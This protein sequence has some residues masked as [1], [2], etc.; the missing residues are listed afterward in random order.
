[1]EKNDSFNLLKLSNPVFA[2]LEL[3][4]RC[5]N[6]CPGCPSGRDEKES[7][8]LSGEEW[9]DV[10]SYL[11]GFI[12]EIRLTGGEPTYHP[13]FMNILAALIE[14]RCGF[15]IYTNGLWPDTLNMFDILKETERFNGFVFSIHGSN[16]GIHEYFTGHS[17]YRKLL[18]NIQAAV[19]K[20]F[21]VHTASVLGAFNSGDISGIIRRSADL[22]AMR[23]CF[24]RYIGPS[25]DGIS[26]YR[27]DLFSV[28][29]DI[30]RIPPG[31]FSYRIGSCFPKCF[32]NSASQCLAGVTNITVTPSGSIKC[33]PFSSEIMGKWK[34]RKGGYSGKKKIMK[35]ASDFNSNC[36]QCD[37]ISLCMGG[38]RV[39]R[40]NFG[41]RRDPLMIGLSKT[42]S[43]AESLS[44][45]MKIALNGCVNLSCMIRREKFGYV[46]ISGEK[47]VP[48]TNDGYR[49]L[50]LCDGTRGFHEIFEIAGEEA[51]N[52]LLSLY[53]RDFLELV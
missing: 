30:S 34:V 36:L 51:K 31:A 10:I 35:W 18:S 1:M 6:K 3:T 39:M 28:L 23:H 32:F 46:L 27:E 47:V 50:S 4:Y 12:S 17:D 43:A 11:S 53:L 24:Q 40:R 25:R 9:A 22:G 52:F 49:I 21:H 14:S 13:E 41:F 20:G 48:V 29:S 15:K 16:A 2:Y 8:H 5:G 33:C 37:E 38:C 7:A 44:E 19:K 26:I 42:V 45:N